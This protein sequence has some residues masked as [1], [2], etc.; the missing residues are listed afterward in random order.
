MHASS[1]AHRH[2]SIYIQ[3]RLCSRVGREP[4]PS[5][6]TTQN[7]NMFSS[8]QCLQYR[9][10][11]IQ[12][13][14]LLWPWKIPSTPPFPF[15]QCPNSSSARC[16]DS[17][18]DSTSRAASVGQVH[19]VSPRTHLAKTLLLEPCENPF[20]L[21][22]CDVRVSPSVACGKHSRRWLEHDV[23]LSTPTLG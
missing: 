5:L 14:R 21:K 15:R 20:T 6:F 13:V 23:P 1:L 4:H 16:L 19:L 3:G 2:T 22:S 9:H 18:R 10:C 7:K 17:S 8:T 12:T 11:N